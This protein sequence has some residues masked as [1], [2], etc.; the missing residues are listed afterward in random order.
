MFSLSRQRQSEIKAKHT[1]CAESILVVERDMF[2][3][4]V[5]KR[6]YLL[7]KKNYTTLDRITCNKMDVTAKRKKKKYEW[8]TKVYTNSMQKVYSERKIK[9]I[10]GPKKQNK[11]KTKQN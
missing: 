4:F 3:Q 9:P 5:P 7:L 10:K 2:E 8:H 11:T 1:L 6:P